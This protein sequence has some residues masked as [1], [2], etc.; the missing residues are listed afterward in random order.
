YEVGLIHGSTTEFPEERMEQ[1]RRRG[2]A[3]VLIPELVRSIRPWKDLIAFLKLF[4]LLRKGR[5]DIVHTHTSKA[6]ILGRLAA[7]CASVRWIVHTPHGHV[8]YGY[9]H[10]LIHR[11]IIW[12]ERFAGLFTDCLITLTQRG[13]EEHLR[14]KILPECRITW[15][16]SGID[17]E[18]FHQDPE[19]T[20]AD[21]ALSQPGPCIGMIARLAPIKGHC[22]FLQAL[23]QVVREVPELKVLLAGDGPLRTELEKMCQSLGIQKHVFFLGERKDVQRILERCDL[24]ILSSLN[25]GMGRVLLEAQAMGKP[26]IGTRVGGIPEVIQEGETGILV[27]PMDPGALSEAMLS[28]LKDPE[29][30]KVMGDAAKVWV[31]QTFS[32]KEMVKRIDGVYQSLIQKKPV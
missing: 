26:V 3:I 22:Y 19:G 21:P 7:K 4:H 32:I 31:N 12:A 30:R 20:E 14:Y 6:G 2:V 24:V 5:Y 25:E 15:A 13:K 23:P 27:P 1:V 29:K 11:G 16:Y 8:F 18:H 28:L 9:F 17:V 10:P